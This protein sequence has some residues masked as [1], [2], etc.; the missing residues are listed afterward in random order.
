LRPDEG[1]FLFL[2]AETG[3][4]RYK[5]PP[6]KERFRLERS[7]F[8]NILSTGIDIQWGK[9]LDSYEALPGGVVNVYF[10]DGSSASGSLLIGADGNNSNGATIPYYEFRG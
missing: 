10:K 5:V 6:S 2:N 8:R 4:V 9:E 1:N 7:K 3:E